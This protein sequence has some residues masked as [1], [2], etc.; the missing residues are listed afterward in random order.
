MRTSVHLPSELG[1]S[2]RATWQRLQ[3]LWPEY[4]NPFLSLTFAQ[5]VESCRSDVRVAVIEDGPEVVGFLPF[6]QVGRGIGRPV[7]SG[8]SDAQALLLDDGVEVC[9][10]QLLREAGLHVW[11][12]DHLVPNLAALA[13]FARKTAASA[14]MDV[15]GGWEG[16]LDQD[17]RSSRR[18]V[19]SAMQKHR[20][21]E[22]EVGPTTTV[23]STD[24]PEVLATMVRWK[25]EQYRR[26]GRSDRFARPWVRELLERLLC[27]SAGDCTGVLSAMVVDGHP[28]AV[29]FGMRSAERLSLWFPAYSTESARYSP[30]LL[31]FLELARLASQ[32]GIGLLDLGKGEEEY[33]QSLKSWDYVVAEGALSQRTPVA[34]LRMLRSAPRTYVEDFVLRHQ[35]LR[36]T[37][38]STLAH[39]GRV[40]TLL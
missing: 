20:K 38:R 27:T 8:V 2:E 16:Y 22:R 39:I 17:G 10:R 15:R 28:L 14:V 30:G 33:K 36:R 31:L 5:V 19:R 23:F 6:Q 35:S 21:L 11:E 13:P 3:G 4:D 40:R 29:H 18:M 1:A 32:Q 25:S 7:A 37:A 9:P 12:F 26:T 24:A 34:A